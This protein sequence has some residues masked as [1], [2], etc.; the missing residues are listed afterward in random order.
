M[1]NYGNHYLGLL[2]LLYLIDGIDT[3][4][5][6]DLQLAF[7]HDGLAWHR[8]P[9]R[10]ALIARSNA[11]GLFPTY[12][13]TNEP[14][15][16]GDELWL[17]YSEANGAHPLLP[18]ER[19]VS[20]IRAATWRKDGFVSLDA[21]DRGTLITPPLAWHGSRLAVNVNVA[22]GGAARVA[23]LNAAGQPLPGYDLADCDPLT[24]D[25]LRGT[26]TWHGK[27]D[28]TALQG[29]TL[30]LKFE[31]SRASLYSYRAA[32]AETPVGL[33]FVGDSVTR[34]VRQGVEKHQTFCS[35]VEARLQA[36]GREA[37]VIN[38]GVGSDTT[39]GA[40]A[41]FDRDVLQ[42]RP[43][44]VCIMFGLNDCWTPKGAAAPLVSLDQY[45]ANLKQMI[46]ALREQQIA[47]LL[48]TSNPFASPQDRQALKP[49]VAACRRMAQEEKVPLID[50]YA[51][52]AELALDD[53]WRRFYVDDCHMNAEGN[54]FIADVIMQ[55]LEA[56][57]R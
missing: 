43:T 46:G 25:Q 6:G 50:L 52:F 34:G 24:G 15:E 48:M 14:L 1:F 37:A 53:D 21:G 12:V 28:L 2:S 40:L 8:Q 27:S 17:Y 42:H 23:V 55:S 36:A 26:A 10:A 56:E 29:K 51:R 35:L 33:V 32:G 54:I 5:G 30:R 16:I 39:Q 44:H 18:I 41:R 31:L 3:N 57:L 11:A 22:E 7:S 45:T 20:Q 49:Y 47:P 13:S 38:A 4:G 9:E 19:A